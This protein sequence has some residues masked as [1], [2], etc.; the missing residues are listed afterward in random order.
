MLIL[1]LQYIIYRFKY[2]MSPKIRLNDF[3]KSFEILHRLNSNFFFI[4]SKI[5]TMHNCMNLNHI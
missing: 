3:L 1:G 5:K 4:G 2:D